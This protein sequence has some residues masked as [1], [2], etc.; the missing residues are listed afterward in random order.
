MISDY[1]PGEISAIREQSVVE[2]LVKDLKAKAKFQTVTFAGVIRK[3]S[4]YW[5]DFVTE[6]N[7]VI[8]DGLGSNTELYD[9][10]AEKIKEKSINR[11]FK[12]N[13]DTSSSEIEILLNGD[14]LSDDQYSV[15]GDQ[16]TLDENLELS[17][18]DAIRIEY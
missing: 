11:V 5:S 2:S 14:L 10:L 13:K 12:L 6:N 9:L 1:T 7:A 4:S 3:I 15:D 17:L 18:G 16:L 8:V